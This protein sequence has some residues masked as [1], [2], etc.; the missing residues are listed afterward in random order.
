MYP[1]VSTGL[2]LVC[3]GVVRRMLNFMRQGPK[4]CRLSLQQRNIIS[5]HLD[6]YKG[7]LPRE[8]ARQPR[9]LQELDRWKATELR[10]FLLYTGPLVLRKVV[11][12]AL[13]THFLSLRVIMSILLNSDEVRN[14]YLGYARDLVMYFVKKCERIYGTTFTVYNV[15][16][17]IHLPDDVEH[18]QCPLDD[19]SSFPF[20]NYLRTLKK[21]VRQSKNPI[22]QVAKR[23]T[24]L[25]ESTKCRR[26]NK[27]KFTCVS[28]TSRDGCFLLENGDFV[29]IK[30]KCADG[31]LADSSSV[32]PY[33]L[34]IQT[35]FDEPCDSKLLNIARVRDRSRAKRQRI[36]RQ[37]LHR[38][39]VC[40]PVNHA[41]NSGCVL[42]PMLHD[43]ERC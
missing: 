16:S 22:A 29:F 11:S 39:V 20:E 42:F 1:S 30:E 8:F 34:M 9:G 12:P 26:V 32:M 23:L 36:L 27:E 33:T 28:D 7:Q 14:R 19:V 31:R 6:S 2:H 25:E 15:H 37:Q 35:F 24:E 40:L 18:F 38:K 13:Y 17:L 4:T 5:Y 3:L 43:L 41:T 21:M 10:Q